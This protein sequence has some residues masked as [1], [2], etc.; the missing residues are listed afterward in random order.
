[1]DHDQ[2][3]KYHGYDCSWEAGFAVDYMADGVIL[4]DYDAD[5]EYLGNMICLSRGAVSLLARL[6]KE[7]G[8]IPEEG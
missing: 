3:G 6:L 5:G 7:H 1:M 2:M 4:F 8:Y